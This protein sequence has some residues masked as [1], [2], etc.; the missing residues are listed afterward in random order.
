MNTPPDLQKDAYKVTEELVDL[1]SMAMEYFKEKLEPTLREISYLSPDFTFWDSL[2]TAKREFR[3]LKHSSRRGNTNRS[4]E[5][6]RG[7]FCHLNSLYLKT[8]DCFCIS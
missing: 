3:A 1:S 2:A 8:V 6:K 5:L 7:C 4:L